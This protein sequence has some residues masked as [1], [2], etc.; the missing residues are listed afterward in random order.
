V[1]K[2]TEDRTD[3][4][5]YD[6]HRPVEDI[7]KEILGLG[8]ERVLAV[9][10]FDY[11]TVKQDPK[12]RSKEAPQDYFLWAHPAGV[13]V[14]G[15][16]YHTSNGGFGVNDVRTPVTTIE[17]LGVSYCLEFME[18][19]ERRHQS[20]CQMVG[21]GGVDA[22]VDGSW[23]RTGSHTING[24]N[25]GELGDF[26]RRLQANGRLI[27][28]E[29]WPAGHSPY[30]DPEILWPFPDAAS[31]PQEKV[32]DDKPLEEVLGISREDALEALLQNVPAS[33]HSVIRRSYEGVTPLERAR[34]WVKVEDGLDQYTIALAAAGIRWASPQDRAL[35][36]HWSEVALGY[37]GEDVADWRAVEEGPAGLGLPVALLYAKDYAQNL[38]RLIRAIEQA[39]QE[40]VNRWAT[41]VDKAGFTLPL[42]LLHRSFASYYYLSD[43]RPV[44][45]EDLFQV[46]QALRE[47]S[48]LPLRWETPQR[49]PLGLVLECSPRFGRDQR[50]LDDARNTFWKTLALAQTVGLEL[51]DGLRW[52]THPNTMDK[53]SKNKPNL[54]QWVTATMY[55][56]SEAILKAVEPGSDPSMAQE[57]LAHLRLRLLDQQ[58]PEAAPTRRSL[59]F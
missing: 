20:A 42:R 4:N 32:P 6:R 24:S 43:E 49:T 45:Q 39:P 57:V 14:H 11:F 10:S 31:L 30:L 25:V 33:L 37:H 56:P 1:A 52:R 5:R 51:G 21:S 41:H 23:F 9:R 29:D 19:K 18:G 8:F 48:E 53:N 16:T 58:L 50:R 3:Y 15:H 12:W 47:R 2:E 40:V 35:L 26:L 36:R 59:R 13:L 46:I 7:E 27:R 28:C 34:D 38:P 54:P 17:T 22:D 44:G 55:S